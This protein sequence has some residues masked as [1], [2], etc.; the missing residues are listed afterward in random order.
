MNNK[1]T[2]FSY[3]RDDK[4]SFKE[5]HANRHSRY[6]FLLKGLGDDYKLHERKEIL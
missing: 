2:D 6:H 3:V 4:Y 1:L 5:L